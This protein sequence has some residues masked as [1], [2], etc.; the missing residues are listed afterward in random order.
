M[1]DWSQGTG[2]SGGAPEGTAWSGHEGARAFAAVEAATDWL[3]GYPFVLRA[4]AGHIG[5]GQVLV[6]YGCGPGKVAD[7]AARVL[8]ARVLGAD[9]SPEMLDLARASAT[10]VAEYHLVEN[11]R[12]TDLPDGCADAVMCNHVLASLPTED[13]LLGVFTE[14]RRL[15][16][17]D[18][19]LVLL[20]TDPACSG[21]E[22]ASLRIG[23]PGETYAPG[24]PVTV[25]LRRTDGS[26]QEMRNHA[27]PVGLY[28]TLL[29]R[30]RFRDVAQHRPTVDEAVAVADPDLV[31]ARPWPA[32]RAG[33]PLVITTA[34]AAR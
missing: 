9:T 20:T 22:Y 19:P 8:G 14:I 17:P 30:A 15:L 3:L 27:W 28:P 4:L 12:V 25:R 24:D 7:H 23:E 32:E 6:D 2:P 21:T 33:P 34:L 31:A 18:A 29:E 5:A 13:A 10:A 1:S 11:G 26:W 16:R